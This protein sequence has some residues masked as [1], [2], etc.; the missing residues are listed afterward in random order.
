MYAVSA[1]SPR[2]GLGGAPTA[3]PAAWSNEITSAQPEA[4]A[5]APWTRTTVG[6]APAAGVVVEA[7]DMVVPSG[8]GAGDG[9]GAVADSCWAR[10]RVPPSAVDAVAASTP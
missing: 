10:A 5:K 1:D 7:S 3:T 4:S 2:S 8:W 9:D 6:A